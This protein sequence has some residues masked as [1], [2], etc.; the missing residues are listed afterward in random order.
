M[1]PTPAWVKKLTPSGP[2]GSELLAQERG[3]SNLSVEKLSNFLFTKE[4]L[5]RQAN[6]LKILEA[7]PVFNKSQNYFDGRVDRFRTAL[8]RA[9]RLQQLKVKHKWSQ[10]EYQMASEVRILPLG[11]KEG[12][13][14]SGVLTELVAY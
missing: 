7:E 14:E 10:D 4:I 9:K 3:Q 6:L 5:T 8:A 11:L 1:A 12:V 13:L 2:Q